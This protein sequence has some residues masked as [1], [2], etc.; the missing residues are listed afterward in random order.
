MS[1]DC[2]KDF[3]DSLRGQIDKDEVQK[4]FDG[5]ENTLSN[6]PAD[7]ISTARDRLLRHSEEVVDDK[8][9]SDDRK[10]LEFLENLERKKNVL[11]T[12]K[13]LKDKTFFG[14]R[15][16][17][18]LTLTAVLDGITRGV[19]GSKDSMR[20]NII[21]NKKLLLGNLERK[22]REN[23]LT[24][25][26]NAKLKEADGDLAN[27]I[28]DATRAPDERTA[29][30]GQ[31]IKESLEESE[32]LLNEHGIFF[33]SLTD[34]ITTN[35]H[36]RSKML[37]T[38]ESFN[39]RFSDLKNLTL[40][41]RQEKAFQ[42]WKVFTIPL[43]K[44]RVLVGLN[45]QGQEDFMRAAYD[46][47]TDNSSRFVD[48]SKSI[49]KQIEEH[50]VLDWKDADSWARY[51]Q[52]YGA[53]NLHDAIIRELE[54]TA[55]RVAQLARVGSN[56]DR[57][58]N[59]IANT[60]LEHPEIFGKQTFT[61]ADKFSVK[62][63]AD[64]ALGRL[65]DSESS[66]AKVGQA[67]RS[68]TR[69]AQLGAVMF[70]SIP[71][72]SL[73]TLATRRFYGGWLGAT[74]AL[75]KSFFGR[76]DAK[77]LPFMRDFLNTL[78]DMERGHIGRFWEPGMTTGNL[79]NIERTFTKLSGIEW[80]DRS[81]RETLALMTSRHLWSIRAQSF[82][83]IIARDAKFGED[84][85]RIF[86]TFNITE[87][88]WNAFRQ[89]DVRLDN[90]MHYLIPDAA[91]KIEDDSIDSVLR[92]E[93]RRGTIT[94]TD[95]DIK[96]RQIRNKFANYIHEVMDSGILRPDAQTQGILSAGAPAGTALGQISRMLAMYKSWGVMWM[97][98]GM[99]ELIYGRGA[100]SFSDA[101]LRGEGDRAAMA[102][103]LIYSTGL[104]Y[105]SF[106]VA[107]L[108]KGL[109]PPDPTKPRVIIE[110][111]LKGGAPFATLGSTFMQN[112]ARWNGSVLDA[113][114]GPI[115]RDVKQS[116]TGIANGL[117]GPVAKSALLDLVKGNT[118]GANLPFV[119]LGWQS[120]VMQGLQER[121]HPGSLARHKALLL[122][123]TGQQ[124]F[125]N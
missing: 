54:T 116:L 109:S 45:V 92:S 75:F 93:G 22:L 85:V 32:K 34:R 102:Q 67:I 66:L 65:N 64:M 46:S 81:W 89:E 6:I 2:F 11:E 71:D 14:R 3:K 47:I 53:G 61:K 80:W 121:A 25:Q 41:E 40:K 5:L 9:L 59:D 31:I 97:K 88:D 18:K 56:P 36:D 21:V 69:I 62:A 115:G 103:M 105:L 20:L 49:Q 42:R 110:S 99:G 70:A 95:R 44:A 124:S 27:A 52:K 68:S 33:K 86:K 19:V 28:L 104:G 87:N 74:G 39:E 125:I 83:D 10:K 78:V 29:T 48:G 100:N 12:G 1:R 13:A 120:L 73:M 77:Q 107:S 112:N 122:K 96:R 106:S 26:F 35:F 79:S 17:I 76:A 38:S 113:V 8:K 23:G 119:G 30:L 94:D 58:L 98:K 57:F 90:K 50:R 63:T 51:N 43:L 7:L 114:T 101:M 16:G 117:H 91:M 82:A 15:I 118:W 37:D 123:E 111:F 108:F 84:N 60:M 55:R 24:A 72:I 4:T